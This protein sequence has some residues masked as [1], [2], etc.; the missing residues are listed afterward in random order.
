M[1]REYVSRLADLDYD[2]DIAI[3][4]ATADHFR[5]F[6]NKKNF[7]FTMFETPDLPKSYIEGIGKADHI[8]VPCTWLKGV[9]RR[10]TTKPVSV[11]RE[12]VEVEKFTYKERMAPVYGQ[13][14]RFLWV[15]APNPRKGYFSVAE[16]CKVIMQNPDVEI[17]IKT[18]VPN[19]DWKD[20]QRK[21]KKER[22]KLLK[23]PKGEAVI[24]RVLEGNY[25][26]IGNKVFRKGPHENII[27]DTRN[28]SIEELVELYHSAHAFIMPTTGEG[29]GLTLAEAMATGLPCIA[30]SYS[31][32][33]DFFNDDVGYSIRYKMTDIELEHYNL[34]TQCAV[35]DTNDLLAKMIFVFRNY[36]L[37]LRK[38]RRAS[39]RIKNKFTWLKAAQRLVEIINGDNNG[40]YN[41]N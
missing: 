23:H 38:G 29:F 14:F 39:E 5:P 27:I 21:V 7:L 37:A 35:P 28:L 12:G 20:A 6:E 40:A 30:T 9:F 41:K 32:T 10:H 11:C 31:G 18:T 34:K 13:K 16:I 3:S 33:A 26:E 8:I 19:I 25:W 2:A 22:K 1:M 36:G 4:I 17:Y 24:Q 15:G